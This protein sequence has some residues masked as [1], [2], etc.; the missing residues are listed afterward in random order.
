MLQRFIFGDDV[1]TTVHVVVVDC[2][3]HA[4]AVLRKCVRGG[5]EVLSL[6]MS[7]RGGATREPGRQRAI[8]KLVV[9]GGHVH[10]HRLQHRAVMCPLE[11][12]IPRRAY[13]R[14]VCRNYSTVAPWSV[15]CGFD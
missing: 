2:Q 10:P 11:Q 12:H 5:G 15:P 6:T 3:R 13:K 8:V 7:A 4:N 9:A 1:M 14:I